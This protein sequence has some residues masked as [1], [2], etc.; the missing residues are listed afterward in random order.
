[1]NVLVVL[2]VFIAAVAAVRSGSG[3]PDPRRHL[4]EGAVCRQSPVAL[5]EIERS[6]R[7]LVRTVRAST[8]VVALRLRGALIHRAASPFP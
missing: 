6:G 2:P 8:K 5:P 4:V 1:M 7:C 3:R